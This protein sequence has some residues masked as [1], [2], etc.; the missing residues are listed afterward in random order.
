MTRPALILF[1]HG[2]TFETGQ[3]PM[4]VGARTDLPLTA[5]GE[6]Q[7]KRAAAYVRQKAG[8]LSAIMA[9]PLQR[10]RRFADIIAAQVCLSVAVDPRLREIDYG[11]WE[12]LDSDVIKERYG[13]PALENWET[14]NIWPE[15]M[16]WSP[17][18]DVVMESL[19]SFL[20]EQHGQLKASSALRLAVT[21]NGILRLLHDLVAGNAESAAKVKTGHYCRLVP[22][23]DG[24]TI[25]TWNA[26]PDPGS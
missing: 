10:T 19:R 21:S 11:L 13:A 7:A 15:G 14:K 23:D 8:S 25:Q 2:N 9:G 6:A 16:N 22:A 1:R 3:T 20:Q 26:S 4:W 5:E 24:W 18:F 17:P 12:G